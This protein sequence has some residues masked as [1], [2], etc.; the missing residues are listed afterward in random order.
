MGSFL[1]RAYP[2]ASTKL[3]PVRE[4]E[5]F[6]PIPY[7]SLIDATTTVTHYQS[8]SE[9]LDAFYHDKAERDRV[10]QQG[11]ELLKKI[12]NELKRNQL[13][14]KKRQQT[15]IDSENAEEFRQKVSF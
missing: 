14:L 13:K 15:L 8:L 12:E 9:L 11:G 4:K 6:T 1:Y 7:P 5:Y 10:K 3:S 2:G